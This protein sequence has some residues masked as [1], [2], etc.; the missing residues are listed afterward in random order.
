MENLEDIKNKYLEL[1]NL[2]IKYFPDKKSKLS[3]ILQATDLDIQK[4]VTDYVS[5]VNKKKKYQTLLVDRNINMFHK[6]G[7]EFYIP[8]LPDMNI[9][10]FLLS[11]D[12]YVNHM[13]W[14]TLQIIYLLAETHKKEK[15][16]SLLLFKIE[17][18]ECPPVTV[19]KSE[20]KEEVIDNMIGD[21]TTTI[22]DAFGK[23][24]DSNPFEMIMHTSMGIAEKY[25]GQ[26]NNG[27][28][29]FEQIIKSM[30]KA[31]GQ[32]EN[33]VSNVLNNNPLIQSLMNI[34]NDNSNPEEM[35][36]KMGSQLGI[37]VGGLMNNLDSKDGKV[38]MGG[39]MSSVLS[40][41]LGG[42]LGGE[43]KNTEQLTEEQMKEMEDFFKNNSQ[44]F[45]QF[46]SNKK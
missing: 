15:W 26:L 9:K 31:F 33:E 22:K 32:D 41:G 37:D 27:Q 13:I 29:N 4:Y 16:H 30:S 17:N 45:E 36:N 11:G 6:T 12:K 19:P 8:F 3:S 39:I 34:S 23:K 35:L 5:C 25:Q 14:E 21:I 18:T 44:E 43:K 10:K 42:L 2:L 24:T 28:I 40:G 1:V 7:H 38:N 46:L 20:S